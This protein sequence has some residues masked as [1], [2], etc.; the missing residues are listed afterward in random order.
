[1][2][3]RAHGAANGIT[4]DDTVGL[5]LID[6][7]DGVLDVHSVIS[8]ASGSLIGA[9]DQIQEFFQILPRGF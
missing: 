1:M 5:H 6:L 3:G 2:E 9:A 8:P 4:F 7:R